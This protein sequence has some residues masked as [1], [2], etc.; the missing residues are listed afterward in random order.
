MHR[1]YRPEQ[2]RLGAPALSPDQG[3]RDQSSGSR[4]EHAHAPGYSHSHD[5]VHDHDHDH[6][7]PDSERRSLFAATI[8]VGLLLAADF[9]LPAIDGSWRR[10]LGV[11]LALLAAVIGGGRVVYLALVAL[12]EGSIGAD[13]ALAVACIAAALLGEYFVAAEVVFIALVGECLEAFTFERARRA[14]GGLLDF[15]PRQARVLR[16]DA[17][18]EVPT[19]ELVVGD[20]VIV[21]PGE[22]IAVDGTVVRGRSAVEEAV[23]TGESM[24]V[25][26]GE[27]DPVYTGTVN[28]FGRLEIRALKLGTETTLGQVIRLLSESQ[29]HRAPIERTADRYARRFLPVVLG[30][31]AVVLLAT[32]G[33]AL[34]RWFTSGGAIPALDVMPALAVLVVACPCALVLATPA[35]VLAATARLAQRGVLV[36]G[37]SAIEGLARADTLA[38]DKTGTLTEGRPELGECIAFGT[39]G[40]ETGTITR[41]VTT[42]SGEGSAL[43]PEVADRDAGQDAAV[44][45]VLRLAAGAEQSSEH[46]LA[47]LLVAEAGRRGL[48]LPAIEDFQAHPGAGVWARVVLAGDEAG[49]EA[50]GAAPKHDSS[51]RAVLVGNLRL[52]REQG[53]AVPPRVEQALESLDQAGQTSLLVV[54]DG[55]I[56]GVIG[57][58]DRVRR[59]A[60][61]VIH[62]LKHLG[63]RDLAILTGDRPA[64]ARAV[65]KKVHIAQVEAELTPAGKAAWI[66]DRRRQ[67]RKVAMVGDGIND[68]PALARANVGIALAGVGSDLAAEAGSVVLLGDPLAA[69]PESFRL[70]R[71]TVRVIHQNILIFAF[72]FNGLAILLAGLRALGPVAAAI[73]HQA[74]SLLVLLNAIRILGFERWHTFTVARMFNRAVRLCKR[75]RPSAALDWVWEQRRAVAWAG[76]ALGF[77][78]YAI[79]GTVIVGPEQVGVLRRLGR[80][81]PPLLRPGLHVRWPGPI[82]SVVLV[83]PMQSRLARVGLRGPASSL[84]Q[85]VGWSATH[86]APRDESALFFTGDENLVELAGVVEYRFTESALPG[87]LFGVTDVAASVTAAAEGVMR[88]EVGRTALETVLVSG[89]GDFETGLTRRVQERLNATGL[90]VVVE[91]MRVVDAHP[92]REVVPAYRDVSAAVSDA[93]RSKNQA[94]AA[95]AKRHF[96]ALAESESIRDAARAR[97]TQLVRRAEGEKGAFLAQAAAHAGQPSLTEFRL[98]WDTL[99]AA[100]AGRPKLILDRKAGGR[101]HVWLA[102]PELVSST[103]KRAAAGFPVSAEARALEPDD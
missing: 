50:E 43:G 4:H 83:E 30:L 82:E 103:L 7:D 66:E 36:K 57:A 70:A 25:D 22:R 37:G 48:V 39:V 98:L 64:P 18:V 68:A 49:P 28:Q 74:G 10:P 35:A 88:E 42:T 69:L 14:I 87:L 8:V 62:E 72:A 24:P 13:I 29:R 44:R 19:E 97:A 11:P 5:H 79:S 46:P 45:E 20:V 9:V 73:V 86:G 47:R 2:M 93:A 71:Q 75:F 63:L 84:A 85:P 59:E 80:F 16:G 58:R 23:L 95:A 100:L 94:E 27:G 51:T 1:E 41:S 67:G 90:G 34:L 92:P 17:E 91:R 78:A 38:F 3:G 77:L 33:L 89:R 12:L 15:Y 56:L 6:H 60:H 40:T 96:A 52:V 65:A 102:D 76:I 99:A 55:Q 21:R 61:D 81:E 54:S 26:K 101:R 32:N 31:A 53:V